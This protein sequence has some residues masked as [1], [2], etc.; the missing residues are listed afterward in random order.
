[1]QL[2]IMAASLQRFDRAVN[3]RRLNLFL[4]CLILSS[5]CYYNIG[6]A[7]LQHFFCLDVTFLMANRSYP[8]HLNVIVCVW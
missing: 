7:L 8:I 2:I 6:P 5:V 1:M 3:K 4:P